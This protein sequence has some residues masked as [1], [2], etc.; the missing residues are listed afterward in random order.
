MEGQLIGVLIR[1]LPVFSPP[2]HEPGGTLQSRSHVS[3]AEEFKEE[4]CWCP[5]GGALESGTEE[6]FSPLA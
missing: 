3:L 4:I 2:H 1:V 6:R 5:A